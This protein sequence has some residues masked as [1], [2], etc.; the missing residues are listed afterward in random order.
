MTDPGTTAAAQAFAVR[1]PPSWF[2]IDLWRAT[3]T[4]ELARAV[5]RRIEQTPE[6]APVRGAVLRFLREVAVDAER[7][8]M[9]F[10]AA[11][12]EPLEGGELLV[13]TAAGVVAAAPP[14]TD[15]HDVDAVASQ[16]T[17]VPPTRTAAGNDTW[18]RVEVVRLPV[19]KAVR[20]TAVEETAWADGRTVPCVS[21]HTLL[22]VP[23][24]PAAL[25]FVLTSPHAGLADA[26]LDLFAAITE[27][28][29]WTAGN[30]P[31]E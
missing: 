16:L 26:M 19:G 17:S 30:V 8:G 12:A 28:L 9:V 13:A 23:G 5:D 20:V 21:M 24:E 18:R 6:L 2:E 10:A 25:D 15:P 31:G 7:R 27:T 11:V 3:R 14:G 4:G 1:L 22:P 29:E